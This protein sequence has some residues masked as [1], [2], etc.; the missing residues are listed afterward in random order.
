MANQQ[1]EV[2]PWEYAVV[3]FGGGRSAYQ[4]RRTDGTGH[5]MP[6]MIN[7]DGAKDWR[8][9]LNDLQRQLTEA[10]GKAALADELRMLDE[11]VEAVEYDNE[12]CAQGACIFFASRYDALT[13]P[14]TE[15][16]DAGGKTR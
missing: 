5:V 14:A 12:W 1:P 4:V 7:E 16:N 9:Y 15:A 8:D 13:A 3:D 6:A 2:A 11:F 10:R